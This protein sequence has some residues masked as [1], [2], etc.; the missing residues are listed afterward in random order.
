[1]ARRG[2]PDTLYSDHGTNFVGAAAEL[3]RARLEIEERMS[4]EA[5]TRA[6]RWLRIP[7]HAPH[8]GGSWERLVRSIKVALSATLHTRA[9]K[10]EVLHTLLLEAEFVVNSRPLTHISV[11]PSDPTALTPNHFLLGSAA[12]RWQPGHFDTSE[13]CSRKQ[14]RA[15][16]ALAEMFWQRWLREYP[17]AAETSSGQRGGHRS[18]S[19]TRSSSPTPPYHVTRGRGASSNG[20]TQ[21]S[22]GKCEWWTF[23]RPMDG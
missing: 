2:Q 11:L 5:T 22:T 1:M 13:E 18:K 15:S 9:P 20:S 12:G 19:E 8:M 10:D 6:I 7:P 16:Q 14:W 21:G 4:D 23:A 17:H 3:S